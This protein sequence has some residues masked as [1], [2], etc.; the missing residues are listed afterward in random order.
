VSEAVRLALIGS[1]IKLSMAKAF[2]ELAGVLSGIDVTYDLI[3]LDASSRDVVPGLIGR[4]HHDGYAG[5][6]VTYPFKEL[7]FGCVTVDDPGVAQIGA[8]NTVVYGR[9]GSRIGW[10]TDYSGLVRRWHA[11][12]PKERPGVIGL[13]GA[14][15]VGRSTAF[16]LAELGA[17]GLRI[18][19]VMP[20]RAHALAGS[21]ARR[22]PDLP[23]AVAT[24]AEAAVD[25]ADGVVNATPVGMYFNPGAPVDL[26]AVG[27][28]R[29]LLD[30]VYSPIETPLVTRAAA[31]GMAVLNGF[32]LFL[33]QGFDSFEHF[34]GGPVAPH[35]AQ[36]L[37][38]AMWQQVAERADA[39]SGTPS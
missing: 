12:W 35:V 27:D 9:S 25:G 4:C 15:G 39:S 23:V 28:Q 21:L 17:S 3:E 18:A 8:V 16:A 33:G 29:W 36:E 6:N 32:E 2:H 30:V 31:T 1:G 37:E 26:G 11:R 34:T 7:A 14:G 20:D 38:V 5:L 19:D 10:N 22:F 24:S 13:I